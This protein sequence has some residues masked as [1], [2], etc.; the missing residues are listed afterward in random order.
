M[1][2]SSLKVHDLKVRAIFAGL[3]F[4]ISKLSCAARGLL[5]NKTFNSTVLF[6]EFKCI[7]PNRFHKEV[8]MYLLWLGVFCFAIG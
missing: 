4:V 5:Q 1:T 2:V 7:I 3:F 8:I 6:S